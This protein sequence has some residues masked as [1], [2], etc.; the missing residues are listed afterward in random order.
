MSARMPDGV[1]MGLGRHLGPV[2]LHRVAMGVDAVEGHL[3][4]CPLATGA[5]TASDEGW[6]APAP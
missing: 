4:D 6:A 1:V 2:P 5:E 3:M